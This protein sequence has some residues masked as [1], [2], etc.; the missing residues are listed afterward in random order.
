MLRH[1]LKRIGYQNAD[2]AI[3]FI[4]TGLAIVPLLLMLT[5]F[6]LAG[7]IT[8]IVLIVLLAMVGMHTP[9]P[10]ARPADK[11]E[12]KHDERHS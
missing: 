1:L 2:D 7:A 8:F 12:K 10:P 5:G 11:A 3:E 9:P 4:M 6:V